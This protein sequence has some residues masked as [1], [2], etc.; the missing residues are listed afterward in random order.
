MN[1]LTRSLKA[2]WE[3]ATK[4]AGYVKGDEFE[5]YVRIT[6]FPRDLYDLLEKTH[7]YRDNRDDFIESSKF[8][9]YKLRLK[10]NG[11]EFFVEAKFRA[12]FQ[13]QILEWGKFFQLKRYQEIDSI[14]PV[15]IAV[16]LSGRPSMPEQVFLMPVRHI[17]FVKLYPGFMQKYEVEPNQPVNEK[18]LKRIL[19]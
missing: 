4:P 18:I 13:D 8:P 6:L 15:F 14:T 9:D 3:E 2:A 19:E 10:S 12:R 11:F 17:K 7:D 16:G 5:Q 1:V